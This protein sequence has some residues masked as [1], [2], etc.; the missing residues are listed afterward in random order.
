MDDRVD[1][2]QQLG[3][4]PGRDEP[5]EVEDM[6]Q[7]HPL[8]FSDQA[9]LDE[10]ALWPVYYALTELTAAVEA[11]IGALINQAVS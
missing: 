3:D 8:G 9:N 4:P 11:R 6:A 10:G 7:T 2:V 1:R 5:D